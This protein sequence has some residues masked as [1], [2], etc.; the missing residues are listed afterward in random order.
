MEIEQGFHLNVCRC[1]HFVFLSI[2]TIELNGKY[3]LRMLFTKM[4]FRQNLTGFATAVNG[5]C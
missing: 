3:Y 1:I 4:V 2:L 5:H